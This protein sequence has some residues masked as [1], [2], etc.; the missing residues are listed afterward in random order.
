MTDELDAEGIARK[1][2]STAF[3]GFDQHEVR[4]FLG[5]VATTMAT[6]REREKALR[7]RIGA[8][9]ARSAGSAA[10]GSDPH[11]GAGAET[12][13]IRGAAEARGREMVGEAQAVRERM[14]K[15]LAR[16]RKV[17]AVQLEQLL[18]A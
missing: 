18:A 8:S 6:L 11:A 7:E 13:P 2:F 5:Q 16:K 12:W 4:A 10:A 9:Q 17:A 15:D 3:R 1:Q 14:L